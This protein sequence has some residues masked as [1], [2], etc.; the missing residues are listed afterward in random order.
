MITAK[1]GLMK[2]LLTILFLIPNLV[3]GEEESLDNKGLICAQVVKCENEFPES[4]FHKKK[5]EALVTSGSC[6]KG[7]VSIKDIKNPSFRPTYMPPIRLWCNA[8]SCSQPFVD[9]DIIK[10]NE[11]AYESNNAKISVHRYNLDS[12]TLIMSQ[13]FM[14]KPF[15][16]RCEMTSDKKDVYKPLKD[17]IKKNKDK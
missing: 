10:D 11:L 4:E 14:N 1:T 2:K 5:Y 16:Y 8:D 3:L 7:Y 13:Y 12:K 15:Y 17:E 9:G 6:K